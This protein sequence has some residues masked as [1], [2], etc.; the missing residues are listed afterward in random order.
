MRGASIYVPLSRYHKFSDINLLRR[1]WTEGDAKER[2]QAI[3]RVLHAL[4]LALSLAQWHSGFIGMD[5]GVE[6]SN[7]DGVGDGES[8]GSRWGADGEA[9][10]TAM[11]SRWGADGEPMG[12]FHFSAGN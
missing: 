7:S 4:T 1:L 6:I 8:M 12:R 10:R 3:E 11:G 9:H 5:S 2:R